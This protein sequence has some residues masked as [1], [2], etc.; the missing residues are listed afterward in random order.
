M[1]GVKRDLRSKDE[2]AGVW[3]EHKWKMNRNLKVLELLKDLKEHKINYLMWHQ[4][5]LPISAEMIRVTH[6]DYKEWSA[7]LMGDE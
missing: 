6:D 2:E 1:A 3:N 7:T 5:V 4:D